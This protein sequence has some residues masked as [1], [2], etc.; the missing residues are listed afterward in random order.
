M[1][2]IWNFFRELIYSFQKIQSI[3]IKVFK[4]YTLIP[5]KFISNL[6]LLEKKINWGKIKVFAWLRHQTTKKIILV[7]PVTTI[8][9]STGKDK[10]IRVGPKFC[11]TCIIIRAV[12]QNC[13]KILYNPNT[14]FYLRQGTCPCFNWGGKYTKPLYTLDNV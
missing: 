1:F 10:G 9:L 11:L 12:L 14:N 2:F 8:N 13:R 4:I 7:C 5:Q 3:F 6:S